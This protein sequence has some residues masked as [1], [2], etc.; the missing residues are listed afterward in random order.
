MDRGA[1]ARSR[2]ARIATLTIFLLW[3][4]GLALAG[5]LVMRAFTR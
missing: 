5:F 4:A 3:L 1:L 2:P